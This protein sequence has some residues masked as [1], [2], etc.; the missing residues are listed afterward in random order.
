MMEF[1]NNFSLAVIVLFSG[2]QFFSGIF[3]IQEYHW[4][5]RWEKTPKR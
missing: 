4:D 1:I 2:Y 3:R 5:L